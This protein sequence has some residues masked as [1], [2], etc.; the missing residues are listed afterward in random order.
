VDA[1][2]PV[3]LGD[4][5]AGDSAGEDTG[6]PAVAG[7]RGGVVRDELAVAEAAGVAQVDVVVAA[8]ELQ[9]RLKA[10]RVPVTAMPDGDR[11][12]EDGPAGNAGQ[13]PTHTSS[14]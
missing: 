14:Y 10:R 12:G 2:A 5:D 8:G 11:E 3:G 4:R 1:G 9:Q 7:L 6:Q 13:P